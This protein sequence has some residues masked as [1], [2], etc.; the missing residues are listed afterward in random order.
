MGAL[1]AGAVSNAWYPDSDKGVGQTFR[2]TGI[3]LA[4][5]AGFNFA[6]EFWPDVS[7]KLFHHKK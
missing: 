1:T 4:T 6:R 2:N 5:V 3:N 7:K